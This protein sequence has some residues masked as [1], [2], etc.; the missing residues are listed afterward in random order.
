[1]GNDG[2]GDMGFPTVE[3]G[4][5]GFSSLWRDVHNDNGH[6][7]SSLGHR[8]FREIQ[9]CYYYHV[10]G[11]FANFFHSS[12]ISPH[13]I[14]SLASRTLSFSNKTRPNF[15][16][17]WKLELLDVGRELNTRQIFYILSWKSD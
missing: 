3:E 12:M 5:E 8:L 4:E 2:D 14:F 10:Y 1:M 13:E 17:S 16:W 7:V 6:H 15:G 11:K 9:Y